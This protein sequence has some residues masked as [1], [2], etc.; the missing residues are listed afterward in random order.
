MGSCNLLEEGAQVKERE[1]SGRRCKLGLFMRY[2]IRDT[3]ALQSK[4]S[5]ALKSC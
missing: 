1:R 4:C 2:D 5:E 3:G